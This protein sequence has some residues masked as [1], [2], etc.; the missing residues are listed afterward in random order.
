MAD[1]K[2][3]GVESDLTLVDGGQIVGV[4]VLDR[5]F[6]RHDMAR[7]GMVD[8]VDHGCQGGRLSRARGSGD[9]DQASHFLGQTGDH[10]RKPELADGR[11]ALSAPA[12]WPAPPMIADSRR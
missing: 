9:Q 10:L 4:Q 11:G 12:A 1:R 3:V 2:G 8:V 5:V 6:D 7:T